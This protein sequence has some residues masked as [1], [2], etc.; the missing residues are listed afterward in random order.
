M[1]KKFPDATSPLTVKQ[2]L[3]LQQE[4]E[5]LQKEALLRRQLQDLPIA[6]EAKRRRQE[7][8]RRY[9]VI[10]TALPAENLR[11]PSKFLSGDLSRH[12]NLPIRER[13]AAKMKFVI[14]MLILTS[15]ASLIWSS[16][17]T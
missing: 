7:Q 3:L 12:R 2:K 6:I 10:C 5:L 11:Q 9:T 8:H 14:L 13:R 4:K 17:P 15:I 1:I 16:I